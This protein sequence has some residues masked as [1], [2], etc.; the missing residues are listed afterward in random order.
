MMKIA[1][2]FLARKSEKLQIGLA[3]NE[4]YR[5]LVWQ[6]NGQLQVLWLNKEDEPLLA[7]QRVGILQNFAI[8]YPVASQYIW[9]KS[10]SLPL[11]NDNLLYKQII[12][13]LRQ[14]LPI[15]LEDVYFDYNVTAHIEQKISH[16][17][18]Y[19][20]R[21]EYADTLHY[22]CPTILDCEQHCRLRTLHY[23]NVP[24]PE[25]DN[26]LNDIEHYIEPSA[27]PPDTRDKSLYLLALGAS[28]WNGTA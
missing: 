10:I 21:K 28:L 15:D 24:L 20:I 16:I 27:F 19:A 1:N 13:I 26:M 9:R 2:P 22:D 25:T 7:L 5:C 4:Q 18:L 8:I 12:Q 14:E 23:F 17:S 6:A 3:E 11:M